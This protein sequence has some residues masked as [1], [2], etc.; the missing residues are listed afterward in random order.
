MQKR[1]YALFLLV[2]KCIALA[3][4]ATAERVLQ[5]AEQAA[6]EGADPDQIVDAVMQREASA[7]EEELRRRLRD[8]LESLL[9]ALV[10][11]VREEWGNEEVKVPERKVF[12]KYT[13][14]YQTRAITDF[15]RGTIRVETLEDRDPESGLRQAI[16]IT[17]LTPEDPRAV[18]LFSD[19]AVPLDSEREP[20]LLG[21]VLDQQG[22]AVRTVDQAERFAAYLAERAR[23]RTIQTSE[24]IKMATYVDIDMVA[25]LEHAQA[26][27]YRSIVTR[28]AEQYQVSRSLVLAIIRTESNFNPFAVSPAPAYGLMQLVPTSGGRDAYRH[29]KGVDTI[30]TPEYLFDPHN[31]VELGTA[32]LDV[33]SSNYLAEIDNGLS[34]EYCVIAAY[35]TGTRNVLDTF[36]TEGAAAIAAINALEPGAVYD[37]LYTSLPYEETRQYIAKVITYRREFLGGSATLL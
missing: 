5:T 32:Y 17:L 16:V 3:G 28:F 20:Y 30:P 27:K 11:E 31:N 1:N 9:A 7:L 8:Q 34:R 33:L 6:T 21:L 4:C 35:N 15:D 24:G 29:A 22:A 19:Q 2:A 14:H 12:V 25:N 26:E 10:D 36:A 23:T 18:D 13:E 37:K